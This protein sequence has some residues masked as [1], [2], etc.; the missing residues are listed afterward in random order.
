MMAAIARPPG[1]AKPGRSV[2]SAHGSFWLC[3][4]QAFATSP[5]AIPLAIPFLPREKSCPC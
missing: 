2:F 5:L 3:H 1:F 4:R